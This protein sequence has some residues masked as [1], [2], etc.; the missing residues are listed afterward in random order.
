MSQVFFSKGTSVPTTIN[1]KDGGIY[2]N[3]SNKNIYLN[4]NSD[5]ITYFGDGEARSLASKLSNNISSSVTKGYYIVSINYGTKTLYVSKTEPTRILTTSNGVSYY[6]VPAGTQGASVTDILSDELTVDSVYHFCMNIAGSWYGDVILKYV[7]DNMFTF[8]SL[9]SDIAT[10]SK[11]TS[12]NNGMVTKIEAGDRDIEVVSYI[13]LDATNGSLT[14]NALIEPVGIELN[15]TKKF[16][17]GYNSYARGKCSVAVGERCIAQGENSSAFGRA[18]IAN[19]GAF[20]AGYG[21]FAWGDY[22]C[23]MGGQNKAIGTACIAVGNLSKAEGNF[24]IAVGKYAYAY[25]PYSYAEGWGTTTGS[26]TALWSYNNDSTEG[27][28]AHVE[29]N[30]SRAK[31]NSSHAQNVLTQADGYASTSIGYSTIASSAQSF[32]GGT[33]SVAAGVNSFAFG[34]DARTS[35][36]QAVAFGYKTSASGADAVAIGRQTIAR[37]VRTFAQGTST[38]AS[39]QNAMAGGTNSKSVGHSSFAFGHNCVAGDKDRIT[40]DTAA[41]IAPASLSIGMA[42]FACGSGTW[43]HGEASFAAGKGTVANGTAQFVCGKWNNPNNNALFIVGKGSSSS[44]SNAVVVDNSGN[45]Y[46]SGDIVTTEGG[47]TRKYALN[48]HDHTIT[49][50]VID[51]MF[52]LTGT[53]GTNKVT[54]AVAPY[55]SRLTLAA[56]T[57]DTAATNPT[58]T[59]RLNYNGYLYATKLYS[60]GTEVS[61]SGHTHSYVPTT[62]G[63]VTGDLTFSGDNR[64]IH[65]GTS[66]SEYYGGLH[67]QNSN[68]ISMYLRPYGEKLQLTNGPDSFVDFSPVEQRVT[69]HGSLSTISGASTFDSQVF[70]NGTCGSLYENIYGDYIGITGDPNTVCLPHNGTTPTM[71]WVSA[72]LNDTRASHV[73]G[74]LITELSYTSGDVFFT[75]ILCKN[76]TNGSLYQVGLANIDNDAMHI[77]IRETTANNQIIDQDLDRQTY[78][79]NV[80]IRALNGNLM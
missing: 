79:K 47:T 13:S 16:A 75:G 25:A 44:P 69:I 64:F 40:A 55:D 43:A 48:S 38:I 2:F 20:A 35:N 37:D 6:R 60:G 39:G 42:T 41:Q 21:N 58:E 68:G 70:S 7:G 10:E 53:S 22:S 32:A 1:L 30:G 62:G 36:E 71:F 50:N 52:N 67:W 49:A 19:K 80:R 23:A 46:I 4:S 31:G 61:V 59:T 56:G 57:F 51:G 45:V 63:T 66:K 5:I 78:I 28:F 74:L 17:F 12:E 15:L 9:P 18:S 11:L 3:T 77:T 24:S 76:S 73:S 54:Y 26:G 72:E 14:P 27:Y 65:F 34:Y 33:D 8:T 29:G